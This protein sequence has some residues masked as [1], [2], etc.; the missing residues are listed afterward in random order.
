MMLTID[1]CRYKKHA[2]ESQA[3]ISN[4]DNGAIDVRTTYADVPLWTGDGSRR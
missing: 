3:F 2:R 4:E 1:E